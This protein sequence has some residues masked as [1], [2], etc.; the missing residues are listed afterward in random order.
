MNALGS[1]RAEYTPA[2][3]FTTAWTQEAG[4]SKRAANG[5]PH[6]GSRALRRCRSRRDRVLSE[7]LRLLPRGVRALLRRRAHHLRAVDRGAADRLPD[8]AHRLRLPGAAALR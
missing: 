6:F 3:L 8:G 5:V 2:S 4:P 1:W 7:V